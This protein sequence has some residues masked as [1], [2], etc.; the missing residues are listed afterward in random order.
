MLIGLSPALALKVI[1][2]YGISSS[3]TQS[4]QCN[5][6]GG[7]WVDTATSNLN[8]ENYNIFNV[9][10]LNVSSNIQ[11]GQITTEYIF[12][13]NNAIYAINVNSYFLYDNVGILSHN[14]M[15]RLLVASDGADT[16]LNY[17]S[18]GIANFEDNNISTSGKINATQ[19]CNATVCKDLSQWGK[20]NGTATS[21][22][23]MMGKNITNV[24]N[25]NV[26][27]TG[28]FNK[29]DINDDQPQINFYVSGSPV[30]LIEYNGANHLVLE[31]TGYD[32]YFG[33]ATNLNLNNNAIIDGS[34]GNSGT[35][36]GAGTYYGNFNG[37]GSALTN[38]A[39]SWV[40]TATSDLIMYDGANNYNIDAHYGRVFNVNRLGVSS[41]NDLNAANAIFN[42]DGNN[43]PTIQVNG[44]NNQDRI[45]FYDDNDV[46]MVYVDSVG[47][48]NFNDNAVDLGTVTARPANLYLG[49]NFY[50]DGTIYYGSSSPS[51]LI[52]V[53]SRALHDGTN[54]VFTFS[55]ASAPQFNGLT[56]AGF[57]KTDSSG[58]VSIDSNT[59]AATPTSTGYNSG[60]QLCIDSNNVLCPCGSCA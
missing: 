21:N 60:T 34:Y 58:V 33:S 16:I 12:P 49:S 32:V 1:S 10:E 7:G 51:T 53:S 39:S 3:N 24:S 6:S 43:I 54:P 57:M 47:R 36:Y 48:I 41:T 52:Q 42:G 46:K 38:V 30:G 37:D 13:T 28:N 44:D 27:G 56:T 18:P 59:Y 19:Y 2:P 5:G 4:C 26:T 14:W 40:G 45:Q 15:D 11:T 20:W 23:N 29:I 9:N 17:Y 50:I 55:S 35:I 31:N 22:L 25:I 8:M